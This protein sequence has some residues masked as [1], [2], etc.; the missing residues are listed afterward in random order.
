MLSFQLEDHEG[1]EEEHDRSRRKLAI[2]LGGAAVVLIG[3]MFLALRRRDR[4][5]E[6]EHSQ[7]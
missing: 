1:E 6:R 7:V 3:L 5:I 2:I 4:P